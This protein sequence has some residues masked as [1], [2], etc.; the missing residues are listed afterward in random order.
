MNLA[1][2]I[3][4]RQSDYVMS[5]ALAIEPG[6]TAANTNG[7]ETSPFRRKLTAKSTGVS[8]VLIA[9][10]TVVL[11]MV[12]LSAILLGLISQMRVRH[13]PPVDESLTLDQA[14]DRPGEI[15][16]DMN[17]SKL[18]TIASWSSTVAPILTGFCMTLFA[19]PAA[20]SLLLSAGQGKGKQ[21][22]MTPY[23]LALSIQLI[24][25]TGLGTVG[26]W[27]LYSIGM[28]RKRERQPPA[29]VVIGTVG[30]IAVILRYA[31]SLYPESL[32]NSSQSFGPFGRYVA[33]YNHST[34][35]IHPSI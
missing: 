24:S 32:S 18:N 15:Y 21:G 7:G 5:N 3:G 27:M 19:F 1:N 6:V 12:L 20:R 14:R 29:M 35:G 10:A 26:K 9:G 34:G 23:Q 30:T 17:Y 16:I 28:K 2:S 25:A 8:D 13:N 22:H 33:A 11:P 31:S 4:E